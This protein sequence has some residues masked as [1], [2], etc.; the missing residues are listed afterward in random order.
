[1]TLF[2]QSYEVHSA[3]G[4]R[5][6][7]TV[8]SDETEMTRVQIALQDALDRAERASLA[9]SEFLSRMS[10]EIRTPL[11]GV[12][13]MSIIALQNV[14]QEEKLIDCLRKINLS[15]KH[16]L[17]LINDVLDM[18]KIESGMIEIK[19]E[20]FD[21]GVFLESL[22]TVIYGQARDREISFET[23]L[24]GEIPEKLVGDSLR[25]NQILM[26]LLSN[27][28]KFTPQNGSVTLR[29]QS[30]CGEAEGLW[31]RFQVKDTGCGIAPENYEKIFMAFEQENA[32]VAHLYGGTGL[33]LSIS[34]RF[35]E[36]MGGASAWKASWGWAA[37]LPWRFPLESSR[38]GRSPKRILAVC[39]PWW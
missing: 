22:V 11:N 1:M 25:L 5:Q 33:R 36:L 8:F 27:A 2:I 23:V 15:S 12:I 19:N 6:Y 21:F 10:H 9:K 16:L 39:V 32:S 34:R 7:I 13:G 18:S 14:G 28:I 3:K 4:H 24:S 17:V 29:I 35:A 20:R 37:R 26:N 30:I 38:S 31:L